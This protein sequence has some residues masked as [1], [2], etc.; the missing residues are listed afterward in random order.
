MG[1][2]FSASGKQTTTNVMVIF[3]NPSFHHIP[4]TNLV[5][6]A[7]V[8]NDDMTGYCPKNDDKQQ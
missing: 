7:S 5:P 8:S 2:P 6:N 4:L 3:L 1:G